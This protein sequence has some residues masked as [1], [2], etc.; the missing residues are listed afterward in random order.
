M[1]ADFRPYCS[2]C[3]DNGVDGAITLNGGFACDVCG[4]RTGKC[5]SFSSSTLYVLGTENQTQLL[6]S[7]ECY[8]V[9]ERTVCL[10]II[11]NSNNATTCHLDLNDEVCNTCEVWY[12]GT[13]ADD[14]QFRNV[15]ADC[16]NIEMGSFVNMR[17]TTEGLNGLV[18]VL[19]IDL[20]KATRGECSDASATSGSLDTS[21]ATR[22]TRACWIMATD[23]LVVYAL[24][25]CDGEKDG[26]AHH[27]SGDLCDGKDLHVPSMKNHYSYE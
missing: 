16:N 15:Q 14:S 25:P 3:T 5:H 19:S 6:S 10:E 21:G 8:K 12:V 2:G 27:Q 9:D 1:F 18:P 7:S 20:S 24:L 26:V 13:A 4:Q 17:D 11:E 23:L 22:F